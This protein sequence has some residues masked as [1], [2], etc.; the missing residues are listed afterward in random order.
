MKLPNWKV[1]LSLVAIFVAGTVT[2]SVITLRIVK[3]MASQQSHFE[4][5]P[6][7]ILS[8][9]QT[10]LALTSEQTARIKPAVEQAARQLRELRST[11]GA[12]IY[13]TLQTLDGQIERELTP[14]QQPQFEQ[15]RREIRSRLRLRPPPKAGEP[16]SNQPA[17]P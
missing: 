2:G 11:A 13:S 8:R 4:R 12:S 15:L 1:S 6:E 9:L 7:L 3:R 14:E 10:K 17:K 16:A 5:W